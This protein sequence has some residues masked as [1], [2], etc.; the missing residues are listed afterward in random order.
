M[1]AGSP[2]LV[3][4]RPRQPES[5]S[6]NSKPLTGAVKSGSSKIGI[7]AIQPLRRYSPSV[8]ASIPALSWSAIASS[9]ARSSAA[10]T[11]SAS[12]VPARAASRVS[13][14]YSG[15]SRL[16]TTSAR[17]TVVAILAAIRATS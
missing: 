17:T 9:T 5:A 11:S 6:R 13:R 14:R 7:S 3:F 8:I 2:S 16:P 15:R 10:R 12:I 1:S 4:Q